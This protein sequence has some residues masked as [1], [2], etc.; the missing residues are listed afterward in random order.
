M[1]KEEA[2][3]KLISDIESDPTIIR[4]RELEEAIKKNPEIDELI[5]DMHDVERKL[6]NSRFY[7]LKNASSDYLNELNLIKD[8]LSNYPYV[9]EY[10]E[11]VDE[12]Y[13][14]IK[15]ICLIFEEEINNR[16]K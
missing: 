8:K 2:V 7:K 10:L 15:N 5:N 1:N 9:D 14:T 3:N 6:V 11:L 16:I 4:I 13:Q 12:A